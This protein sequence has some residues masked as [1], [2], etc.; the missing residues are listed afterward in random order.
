MLKKVTLVPKDN[1]PVDV[2]AKIMAKTTNAWIFLHENSIKKMQST[3]DTVANT[4]NFL[5]MHW[6]ETE[7]HPA[8]TI[9]LKHKFREREWSRIYQIISNNVVFDYEPSD[10]KYLVFLQMEE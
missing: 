8:T 6:E 10:P 9:L 3:A 2:L 7:Q 1:C 5:K 4:D